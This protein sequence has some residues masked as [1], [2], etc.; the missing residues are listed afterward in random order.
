MIFDNRDASEIKQLQQPD[1]GA[2]Q[3]HQDSQVVRM[4]LSDAP[5]RISSTCKLTSKSYSSTSSLQNTQHLSY[6]QAIEAHLLQ[7]QANG[8]M[9]RKMDFFNSLLDKTNKNIEV[10][11]N[12]LTEI[13]INQKKQTELLTSN[14][15]SE[16][17]QSQTKVL[18]EGLPQI[19]WSDI[20]EILES[21]QID[22]TSQNHLMHQRKK[23]SAQLSNNSVTSKVNKHMMSSSTGLVLSRSSKQKVGSKSTSQHQRS[24]AG[25]P[26]KPKTLSSK[27]PVVKKQQSGG[28]EL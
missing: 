1:Q 15:G 13:Q 3:Q 17:R 2:Q 24:T 5:S 27:N 9:N 23:I 8:L 10:I 6:Q 18:A 20:Q 25:S 22:L 7:Q 26:S 14:T 12:Q 16:H 4:L 21:S 28:R 19:P 11:A